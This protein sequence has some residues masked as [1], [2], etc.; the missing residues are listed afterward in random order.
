MALYTLWGE[1]GITDFLEC[2]IFN[3]SLGQK[4]AHRTSKLIHLRNRLLYYDCNMI[5]NDAMD[6]KEGIEES[7]EFVLLSA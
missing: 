2:V 3:T 7:A 1:K 6:M 4:K 5:S